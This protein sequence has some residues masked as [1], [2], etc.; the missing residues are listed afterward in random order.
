MAMDLPYSTSLGF[1]A[2]FGDVGGMFCYCEYEP[3]LSGGMGIG[4]DI[5]WG[6]LWIGCS[7]TDLS[8]NPWTSY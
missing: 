1:A 7:H 4:W 3:G 2:I 8:G 5:A 6:E